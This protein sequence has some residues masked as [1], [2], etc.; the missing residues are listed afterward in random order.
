MIGSSAHSVSRTLGPR[1]GA[2]PITVAIGHRLSLVTAGLAVTL[3]RTPGCEMRLATISPANCVSGCPK[4]AQ[5]VFGDS[6]LLEHLHKSA[7]RCSTCTLAEAKFVWVTAGD[8]ERAH[9]AKVAGEIDEHVPM[10]CAEEDLFSLVQ[11]LGGFR[12][13]SPARA[14]SG[15]VRFRGGLAPGAFRRVREYIDGHIAQRIPMEEL[16]RIAALSLGHFNRAFKQTT[17]VSPHRYVMQKRVTAATN[18]LC[19]TARALAEIALDVGF[20]DQSHF[21]RTYLA[22]TGETPSTCRRRHS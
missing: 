14:S 17:G 13:T 12:G 7:D 16:A 4:S 19:N 20:A 1:L 18:L 5:L 11:R 10:D 9:A 21:S 3:P 15:P 2:A 22:V 8:E 6:L